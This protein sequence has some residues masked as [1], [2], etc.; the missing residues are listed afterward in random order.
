MS[1]AVAGT[2]VTPGQQGF[3]PTNATVNPQNPAQV[4][5]AQGCQVRIS[6]DYGQTFPVI[7][8]TSLAGCSGDPSM[9]FDS[10]GRLF[11]THLSRTVFPAGNLTV[12]GG[13]IA[14]ITTAGTATY[15]PVAI[16]A[17][18]GFGHDKQWLAAD[19]NPVSPYADNL[20]VVWSELTGA[21]SILFSRSTDSGVTWSAPAALEQ[22]GDGFA[23]PSHIAVAAN[24]DLYIAFHTNTCGAANTGTIPLLRD[25]SGGVSFAAGTVPQRNDAF[26]AGEATITCN[27]QGSGG[28]I[29]GAIFWLQGSM[30]PW[31]LPDPTNAA[32]VYVVANDDPNDAFANG[33]DA[34]VVIARSTDFGVSF[35]LS[36][37]DHG[38]GQTFA[39]MPTAHIDQDGNIVA[40]WYDNRSGATNTGAAANNIAG[41]PNFLLDL[42]ATTSRDG[43]VTF[44]NDFQV[45]DAP[46]DPDQGAP[47]RWGPPVD[48]PAIC[49]NDPV[50]G[51]NLRTTRI[52]EY[53]GVFTVDGIGYA[54]WTGNATPPTPP[55]PSDGAGVQTTYFDV[56]SMLGAFPDSFE[57]NESIDFAVVATLGSDSRYNQQ[58]LS[59]HTATDID[60]FKITPIHT[61]MLEVAIDYNEVI[62]DTRVR[63]LDQSGDVIAAGAITTPTPGSSTRSVTVPVVQGQ[64]YFVE[65]SNPT[66]PASIPPQS[67]YDLSIVNTPAPVPF[68]IDLVAGSDSGSSNT[69]DLTNDNTPTVRLRVDVADAAAAGISLLSPA[70]V[71]AGDDGYAV[72]VFADGSF[73]GYATSLGG[74][75]AV[76]EFTFPGPLSDESHFIT[77]RV[78]VF[79]DATPGADGLGG[80]SAALILEVDTAAPAAPGAPDLLASSDTGGIDDDNITTL[81]QPHFAGIGEANALVRLF[82][83]PMQV[84]TALLNTSGEYEVT[85]SVLGDGVYQVTV[86]F[87]DLAGNLTAA[88]PALKV[89]IANSILV[90]PGGTS[91]PAAAP[92]TVDLGM[93][94]ISG[95][96]GIAGA[97]G[98]IG[99][100]G[101]PSV[102]LGLNG[103]PLTILGSG[104][105]DSF[106]Y[107]PLSAAGGQLNRAG[108]AQVLTFSAVGTLTIDPLGGNDVVTTVATSNP[109]TIDVT[110]NVT[111][112]VQV[113]ATLAV[114]MPIANTELVAVAAGGGKDAVTVS[115]SDAVN[116]FVFVDGGDPAPASPNKGDSLHGAGLSPKPF[117]QNSPGGP[118][119]GSG[120]LTIEYPKTTNSVTTVDYSHVEKVTK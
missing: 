24:G 45:N 82:A 6:D 8:N 103:Q 30:Q 63:L 86:R 29:P 85:S 59:L 101:I 107:A 7:R 104:G 69:D 15:T 34:D 77:A 111:T 4:A 46:Y 14:D 50:N 23:W 49:Q 91:D 90:L 74:N 58:R 25:G 54:T 72:A 108:S 40:T 13:Q 43:G 93:G 100:V 84:G 105:D 65:V 96:T 36:R 41:T 80:E 112:M 113:N 57:P 21:T 95:F 79:D 56:F 110:V 117:I 2:D 119:Q 88:S 12:V 116:A 1:A 62:A 118:T 75:D 92:I 120:I 38:P 10:Q 83:G 9:A 73:V 64:T 20:Y 99:I 97:T 98:N 89:T 67:T 28:E 32:N 109:D 48:V 5:V 76:W 47:C 60:F 37:V 27:V 26:G 22:A 52:G 68:A 71:T 70:D 114:Q 17:N 66:S 18:D 31:I 78:R 102:V 53:N 115:A 39:V 106:T 3:E 11:M 16:S 55:F 35:G 87:E 44:V 81:Q 61:G 42:Y 33:D 19:A 51:S 94:I